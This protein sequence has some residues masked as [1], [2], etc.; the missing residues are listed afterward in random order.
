MIGM[1]TVRISKTEI[2]PSGGATKLNAN[3]NKAQIIMRIL[4]I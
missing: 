1:E 3:P 4:F 2:A